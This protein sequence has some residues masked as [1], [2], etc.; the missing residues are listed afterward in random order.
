MRESEREIKRRERE[1]ESEG[2]GWEREKERKRERDITKKTEFKP[3]FMFSRR[4][5]ISY[6]TISPGLDTR[7]IHKFYTSRSPSLTLD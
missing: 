5:D 1:R 7:I 2:V 3:F 4:G 6:V